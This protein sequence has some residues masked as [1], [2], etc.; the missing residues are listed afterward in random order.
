MQSDTNLVVLMWLA[1][2]VSMATLYET[3]GV[4]GGKKKKKVPHITANAMRAEVPHAE[5]RG[6]PVVLSANLSSKLNST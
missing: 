5:N 6:P 2:V 1:V 4:A 3:A